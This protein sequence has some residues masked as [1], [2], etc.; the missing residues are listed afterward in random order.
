MYLRHKF[1]GYY[2]IS[3]NN[4]NMLSS[5]KHQFNDKK[6]TF[7]CQ[8]NFDILTLRE[9]QIFRKCV[10]VIGERAVIRLGGIDGLRKGP[11]TRGGMIVMKSMLCFLANFHASCSASVLETKYI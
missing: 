1:L 4:L 6:L 3:D 7:F 2:T 8:V 10:P 11:T 9:V 5:I